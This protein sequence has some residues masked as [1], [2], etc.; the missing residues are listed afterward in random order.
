MP[1]G[2][3]KREYRLADILHPDL[4]DSITS[5]RIIQYEIPRITDLEQ[6]T[7]E[8]LRGWLKLFSMPRNV[9]NLLPEGLPETVRN[10]AQKRLS[11]DAFSDEDKMKIITVRRA[12]VRARKT[13][14]KHDE[15]LKLK[16]AITSV[17]PFFQANVD[18]VVIR[19]ALSASLEG[20]QVDS[21]ISAMKALQASSSE[22]TV[23]AILEKSHSPSESENEN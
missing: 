16:T 6:I 14:E 19:K 3:F 9:D 18:E 12:E 8:E 22:I 5:M 15:Y 1:I 17:I 23:D 21:V 2:D 13:T 7:G 20:N 10:A 4:N 11:F